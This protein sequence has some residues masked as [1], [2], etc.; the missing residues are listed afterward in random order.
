MAQDFR[1]SSTHEAAQSLA[2]HGFDSVAK[3]IEILMNEAM[4]IERADY[5]HTA[6]YI[7]C[8]ALDMICQ[9]SE[10]GK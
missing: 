7:S 3:A 4:K 2:E 6:S 5:L 1:S 9:R 10:C 8:R